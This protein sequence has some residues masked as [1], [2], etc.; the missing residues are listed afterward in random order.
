MMKWIA[1]NWKVIA[2]AALILFVVALAKLAGYY[3]GKYITAESLAAERKQTIDD[4]TVRQRAVAALDE[5][6]TKELASAQAT[7]DHLQRD[8]AS[9]KRRLQL[10]ATCT[11]Q[12]ATSTGVD[13]AAS[14][15]LTDSAERDYFTLRS[16]IEF[17][18]KQIAGLQQ[19]I[20][21]QC[22]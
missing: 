22:Q 11:K 6:Y 21:E 12:S 13:D 10:N 9:G 3:H 17:A 16:R 8:V 2:T 4:M 15:G 19:Y 20:K 7:I 18:G 14:P 5:K 1:D